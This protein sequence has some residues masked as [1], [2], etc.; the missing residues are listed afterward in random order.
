LRGLTSHA[1]KKSDVDLA[2]MY[3]YLRAIPSLPD[4]TYPG[5]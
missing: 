4:N 3:E 5:L 2:A 1:G